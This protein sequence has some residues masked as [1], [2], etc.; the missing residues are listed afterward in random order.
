MTRYPQNSIAN[1]LLR[2]LEPDDYALVEPCLEQLELRHKLDLILPEQPIEHVYF[3]CGGIV[4]LTAD[5]REQGKTEVGIVGW[6]GMVGT[7]LLL[8]SESTPH[9]AFVQVDGTSALKLSADDFCRVVAQSHSLQKH[10]LRYV[11]TFLVQLTHNS[12]SNARYNIEARLARW[13]LMC[14]DRVDGDEIQ[15]THE[16]MAMMISAQRT[17]VTLALHIL[18]G[19]GM[20]RSKRARV[21]ILDRLKLEELAG[22]SYGL[23]EAEYRRL[24]GAFGRSPD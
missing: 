21:I 9:H 3:P 13:M 6:D 16:F 15:I 20:I 12:V 2:S 24:I 14:H 8:G 19:A 1:R 5:T 18:E 4:S 22:D 10:L 23:P 17:G 7:P 11:Q